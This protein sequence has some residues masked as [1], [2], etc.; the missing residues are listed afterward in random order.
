[1]AD[2]QVRLRITTDGTQAVAGM[3]SVT[4]S[5]RRMESESAGLA[6]KIKHHW[7]SLS[8]AIGAGSLMSSAIN[9][10]VDYNKTLETTRLGIA[11]IFTSM[12]DLKDAQG[13]LIEGQEKFQS[14]GILAVEAQ[15]ELQK[16]GMTTA[17]TYTELV[18]VYQSILAPA[19]SAKMT[20]KETLEITG[21]L[22]NAVKSIGLNMNQIKQEARD[23]VQ[24]GINAASSSLA[25]ALGI[26][27]A[28][29]KKWREQ[30]SVFEELK[31]R[32][33][34]FV[35]ASE[36]FGSTWEGIWSNVKDIASR[37]LGETMQP[38]FEAI[39]GE[40]A[41]LI[42]LVMEVDETT[43]RVK[44]FN[45]SFE[46]GLYKIKGWFSDLITQIR[47]AA[48][49]IDKLGVALSSIIPLAAKAIN[50]V[51]FLGQFKGLEQN[52]LVEKMNEWKGML[53]D[54][55]DEQR[56]KINAAAY[57]YMDQGLNAARTPTSIIPKPSADTAKAGAEKAAKS[58]ADQ[59]ERA[60]M[61][62]QERYEDLTAR[63]KADID[64]VGLDDMS[65]ALKRTETETAKLY[66][67][68][69]EAKARAAEYGAV[70]T[71]TA[72]DTIK[73]LIR[74]RKELLD[75]QDLMTFSE[76]KARE[77]FDALND[78]AA[79]EAEYNASLIKR[80]DAIGK[81]L[82]P[83]LGLNREWERQREI[84][85]AN[86]NLFGDAKGELQA[87]LD[88]S[89][90]IRKEMEIG[91]L[92]DKAASAMERLADAAAGIGAIFGK[93]KIPEAMSGVAQTIDDIQRRFEG[94]T[95]IMMVTDR[96]F[97]DLNSSSELLTRFFNG[98]GDQLSTITKIIPAFGNALL[99]VISAL[100]GI[101]VSNITGGITETASSVWNMLKNIPSLIK[102]GLTWAFGGTAATGLAGWSS[103]ASA[104]ALA[105]A[106]S[107]DFAALAGAWGAGT[108]IGAGA[109]AGT[110]VGWMSS[111]GALATNPWTVGIAAGL[112]IF[113]QKI[114]STVSDWISSTKTI[115][116]S[117]GIVT[118]PVTVADLESGGD[119]YGQA[120]YYYMKKK[121]RLG[122]VSRRS[123]TEY[124]AMDE[125]TNEMLQEIYDSTASSLVSIGKALG[126]DANTILNYTFPAQKIKLTDE[127]TN[128]DEAGIQELI[129]AWSADLAN[130]AITAL[131]GD[132][133]NQ[134]Q[135]EGETLVDTALRVTSNMVVVTAT[136]DVLNQQFTGTGREIT[137]L[138]DDLIALAG[139]LDA[140]QSAMSVY[141]EAFFTDEEKNIDTFKA[142]TATLAEQNLVLPATR[143]GYRELVESLD[144]NTEAGQQA[145]LTLMNLA[146][147][148]D[149]YYSYMERAANEYA[150]RMK[151]L[152]SSISGALDSMRLTDYTSQ[153]MTYAEAQQELA[154]ILGQFRAG[155]FDNPRLDEVMKI[156]T[157]D[158]SQYYATLTDYKR[159]WYTTYNSLA[160]M[161]AIA[162]GTLTVDEQQL[163]ELQGIRATTERLAGTGTGGNPDIEHGGS[164]EG[165]S[166]S[167]FDVS[168]LLA[169]IK[170]LR[171][172]VRSGNYAVALNTAKAGKIIDKWDNEGLPTER[173]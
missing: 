86:I 120:Y 6:A 148:A 41:D 172:E 87:M 127:F 142:L 156:L 150:E 164:F 143:E 102:D 149:E 58:A 98:L 90:A 146:G 122:R 118:D 56:R 129:A 95:S 131:F 144:L 59:M 94:L 51:F 8:A 76:T 77:T 2:S 168:S 108:G 158:N 53:E 132:F 84:L 125:A 140:L 169:E 135:I 70:V 68:W 23:L 116:Q 72:D 46:A 62:L 44:G 106:S 40:M 145:F 55:A 138:V 166:K 160:E 171:E 134:F 74:Q 147:M 26:T 126:D 107:I 64:M 81:S 83:L 139:S 61:G 162:D 124:S 104:L 159:D 63:L 22:T 50:T 42:R 25:T 157:G 99:T 167:S 4:N 111:L 11:A 130:T 71:K 47:Y 9:M 20:F 39:K 154:V 14:A 45:P 66:D 19:L 69:E 117:T 28:M 151:R 60:I 1:M 165:V 34:G 82:D 29:V 103:G 133:F 27:D 16:I 112:A 115:H 48:I 37:F 173:T 85:Q 79:K 128:L 113:G 18:E 75:I 21:L 96:V 67:D 155:F 49:E 101:S 91:I 33:E 15:K 78:I 109:T 136:L 52:A 161:A 119:V 163:R 123:Y 153:F 36:E 89:E 80:A 152:S 32:L 88:L 54:R 105:S 17:A 93:G 10:A 7:L 97:D 31:K 12:T 137:V 57:S 92:S 170:A 35:Y 141:Y 5:M 100:K 121:K 3:T 30:G 110:A 13:K 73:G 65:K 43:G 114:F 38:L 24:G